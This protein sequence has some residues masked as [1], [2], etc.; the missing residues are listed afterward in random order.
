MTTRI[1]T[2]RLLAGLIRAQPWRYAANA[3]L[4]SSVWL[5]PVIPALITREFFDILT[6]DRQSGF[7][8]PTLIALMLGYGAGRIA[9][10]ATAMWNDVHFMFRTGALVRQNLLSR[11]FEMPGAQALEE[12]PGE[13]INRFREDVDETEE[14]LSWTVDMIGIVLFSAASLAILMSIDSR[15]TLFVFAPTVVVIWLSAK[16]RKR[17]RPSSVSLK[18]T[19]SRVPHFRLVKTFMLTK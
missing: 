6:G 5:L 1:P 12:S 4:W 2:T 13:A 3:L 14:T 7:G 15:V 9:V 17:I 19:G 10:M 8:V 16:A 11:V 18:A